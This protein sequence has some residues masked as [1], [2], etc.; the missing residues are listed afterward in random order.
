MK[1]LL[2]A[3]WVAAAA[4]HGYIAYHAPLCKHELE[5]VTKELCHLEPERVCETKTI[6]LG[7]KITGVEKECKVIKTN[8]GANNLLIKLKF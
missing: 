3:S 7:V 8:N 6:P 2:L 4:C 5:T 1:F